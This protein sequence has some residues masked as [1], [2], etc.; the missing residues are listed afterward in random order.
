[1]FQTTNQINFIIP[2]KKP[3]NPSSNPTDLAPEKST[4][5][6]PFFLLLNFRLRRGPS[7]NFLVKTRYEKWVLDPKNRQ[8]QKMFPFF[9]LN[10]MRYFTLKPLTL[11]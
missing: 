1:M 3:S 8:H 6:L 5:E 4:D 9:I 2:G 10:A 11:W 7:T